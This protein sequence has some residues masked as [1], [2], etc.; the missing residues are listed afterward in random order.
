MSSRHSPSLIIFVL[1]LSLLVPRTFASQPSKAPVDGTQLVRLPGNVHPLARAE[2]DRGAAPDALAVN[3]MLLLLSR[4]QEKESALLNFLQEQQEKSS[5]NYY[6]WLTP[7]EFGRRFGPTDQELNAVTSWLISEGFRVDRVASGRQIIEFSGNALTVRHALHTD[8]HK[9][10]VNG[11]DYWAN[12][13][14]PQIPSGVAGLVKGVVS[15]NSFPRTPLHTVVSILRHSNDGA[16]DPLFTIPTPSGRS[17]YAVGPADFATIYNVQPLWN[18]GIDGSG[19]SIAIVSPTNINVQDVREFRSLFGLPAR[20]PQII[21]NGADPGILPG[22]EPEAVTDVEWSGAVARNANITLV[23]SQDT[24]TSAGVDLSALYIIENTVAPVLSVSYGACEAALGTGG[25]A[26]Y[27]SLWEQAA[28]EGITVIVA[29]GDAGSAGCD[30]PDQSTAVKGLAVS[31]LAATPFNVAV[32][33]TDFDQASIAMAYWNSA[34]TPGTESSARSYI[35]EI[36]WN[37]SC[38]QASLPCAPGEPADIAAGSGGFSTIY[39]K[40]AWQSGNGVPQDGHR[41]IPDVS[42]FAATGKNLSTYAICESDL[43]PNHV[44][45]DLNSPYNDIQGVGGTSVSAQ[46]FAGVMA[47]VNQANG[48]RQGNANFNLYR[49]AAQNAANC[50]SNSGPDSSCTFYDVTKGNI[51]VACSPGTANCSSGNVGLVS[52]ENSSVLAWSA[53]AGFDLATGLGSVNVQ[54]LVNNWARASFTATSTS[55]SISSVNITHGQNVNINVGVTPNSGSGTPSGDVALLGAPNGLSKGMSIFALS[56]GQIAAQSTSLAGG[57]YS[58]TAHY[59]GDGVFAGSDSA[60][61]AVTVTPEASKTVLSLITFDPNTGR[62]TNGNATSAAYGSPYILRAD[63]ESVSAGKPCYQIN[64]LGCATGT[65][66]LADNGSVLDGGSFKL[67]SE[68]FAEDPAIQLMGGSHLVQAQ[69]AGDS[70]YTAST[71]SGAIT[72]TPAVTNFLLGNIAAPFLVDTPFTV[73]ATAEA[74]SS[75]V[76]PTGTI[77][78]FIDGAI[79]GEPVTLTPTRPCQLCVGLTGST[80]LT[81]HKPGDHLIGTTYSGDANYQSNKI[82]GLQLHFLY[83]ISYLTVSVSPSTVK[84]GDRTTVTAL[85]GTTNKNLPPTG[86]ITFSTLG[87]AASPVS[88]A[89]IQDA[90]GNSVLQATEQISPLYSGAISAYFGGDTNY[91]L[92]NSAPA[93]VTVTN[94]PD[95][96]LSAN[97]ATLALTA[98]QSASSTLTLSEINGFRQAVSVIC[99]VPPQAK[100]G[101]TFNAQV[102]TPAA[103]SATATATFTV[104]TTAANQAA[105]LRTSSPWLWSTSAIFAGVLTMGGFGRRRS[106]RLL[107]MVV[108]CLALAITNGSCG[109]AGGKATVAAAPGSV[110]FPG[111]ASG[112]YTVSIVG[113]ATIDGR[114]VTHQ[115]DLSVSIK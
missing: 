98:G 56:S 42:L 80:T 77:N 26:F 97:P 94:A 2:F 68:G 76:P 57:N 88:Y 9:F 51:S 6:Q 22:I 103:G 8:I 112:T 107:A 105:L 46:V 4:T 62:L 69:Y 41:D 84:Y 82:F 108:L 70:S 48:G 19:Q 79:D 75:G 78:F 55:L 95:Y 114:Q 60:P 49:L 89:Q 66:S 28:A 86:I 96:T 17:F 35:P 47:L 25:N 53:G 16:P 1:T 113:T 36:P 101:C 111:T 13:S 31:G 50:N 72:I 40:P 12:V 33:G 91:A 45:C 100:I 7:T 102:L 54:N 85:V 93:T 5:P 65:I 3:R 14:D 20:D 23:V 71:G 104:T 87:G 44:P 59:G 27:N 106:T 30:R 109:G 110:N 18:A 99:T 21:L 11:R 92:A 24:E 32:G 34:N 74:H 115:A 63:V 15:L 58:V 39:P 73:S 64:S 29:S 38:G 52:P 67:N 10:A 83:P 37:D 81:V 43:N 90:N 61:V